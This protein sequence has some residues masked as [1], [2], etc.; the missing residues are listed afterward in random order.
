MKRS[1]SHNDTTGGHED[2]GESPPNQKKIEKTVQ[3]TLG[4]QPGTSDDTRTKPI[5]ASSKTLG[6]PKGRKGTRKQ[7]EGHKE[8]LFTLVDQLL[9]PLCK[10]APRKDNLL[11]T[12]RNGHIICVKCHYATEYKRKNN[13]LGSR[14]AICKDRK[15]TRCKAVEKLVRVA[16]ANTLVTCNNKDCGTRWRLNDVEAHE[17]VC[18]FRE[19]SCPVHQHQISCEWDQICTWEGPFNQLLQHVLE[20]NCMQVLRDTRMEFD[21][22]IRDFMETNRQQGRTAFGNSKTTTWKPTLFISPTTIPYMVYLIVQRSPSGT[23]TFL[24]R[25]IGPAYLGNHLSISYS[26]YTV[27]H[28]L[29]REAA[30]FSFEHKVSEHISTQE[31]SIDQGKVGFSMDQVIQHTR[32]G[33]M[34]QLFQ[35]TA[36]LEVDWKSRKPRDEFNTTNPTHRLGLY[37]VDH[38]L[39]SMAHAFGVNPRETSMHKKETCIPEFIE[40]DLRRQSLPPTVTPDPGTNMDQGGRWRK[41]QPDTRWKQVAASEDA[42]EAV[43]AT[44]E[45]ARDKARMRR[46]ALPLSRDE[47]RCMTG[48]EHLQRGMAR[49]FMMR[50]HDHPD[51][52]Q[53]QIRDLKDDLG[54]L[55]EQWANAFPDIAHRP[56]TWVHAEDHFTFDIFRD[57]EGIAAH[58][59]P[60]AVRLR[61]GDKGRR[62]FRPTVKPDPNQHG[63]DGRRTPPSYFHDPNCAKGLVEDCEGCRVRAVKERDY[64]TIRLRYNHTYH[65]DNLTRRDPLIDNFSTNGV[66][67]ESEGARYHGPLTEAFNKNR[68]GKEK[69]FWA[70]RRD[71]WN[72]IESYSGGPGSLTGTHEPTHPS[73]PVSVAV[74]RTY[75]QIWRDRREKRQNTDGCALGDG[76]DTGSPVKPILAQCAKRWDEDLDQ[77]QEDLDRLTTL[78]EEDEEKTRRH[79][80]LEDN[81]TGLR[82]QSGRNQ[83]VQT[84][85]TDS[86]ADFTFD[87]PYYDSE[88]EIHYA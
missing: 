45:G 32:G 38:H 9:C 17:E 2:R 39:T 62:R 87:I 44:M 81:G 12:C 31:D 69:R 48:K 52:N 57:E 1:S 84:T 11:Y 35:Y 86:Y 73:P 88:N 77:M 7:A 67:L 60:P 37:M 15:V 33:S 43:V 72:R 85:L 30:R 40:Y 53:D 20:T 83:M 59:G 64:D 68:S 46:Y 28:K 49:V 61:K 58:F 70:I 54:D 10:E 27:D 3:Q 34:G 14:C 22:D 26:I 5:L 21:S 13:T 36:K 51:T 23:W 78:V 56:G 16:G 29:S 19:I 4:A 8:T 82:R 47:S 41:D 42:V 80:R 25:S 74:A 75:L 18:H 6:A 63:E 24:T 50:V 76:Q 71:L 66:S 55:L 65:E 79:E